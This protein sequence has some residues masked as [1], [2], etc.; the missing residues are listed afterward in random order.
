LR[1]RQTMSN[2]VPPTM[3]AKTNRVTMDNTII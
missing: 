3:Q 2:R 1:L